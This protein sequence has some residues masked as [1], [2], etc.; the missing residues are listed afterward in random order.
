[1]YVCVCVCD[2]NEAFLFG[3]GLGL[4]KLKQKKTLDA[5]FNFNT[6]LYFFS[7]NNQHTKGTIVE[8]PEIAGKVVM[9]TLEINTMGG[10]PN[11]AMS[12]MMRNT[13]PSMIR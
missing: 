3:L 11:W 13:A 1:V 9:T 5:I 12:F 4:G 7:I 10:L 6:S 2:D 8:H